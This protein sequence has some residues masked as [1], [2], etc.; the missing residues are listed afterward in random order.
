MNY[1]RKDRKDPL[2]RNLRVK[3]ILA[4]IKFHMIALDDLL[5][6]YQTK[7]I[8]D[9]IGIEEFQFYQKCI[10]EKMNIYKNRLKR[11]NV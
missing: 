11:I 4:V 9:N 8:N 5:I 1:F 6:E 7:F 10:S 3:R 2:N